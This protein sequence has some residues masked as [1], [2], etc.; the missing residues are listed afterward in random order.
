MDLR[1]LNLMVGNFEDIPEQNSG[2]IRLFLSSTTSGTYLITLDWNLVLINFCFFSDFHDERDEII[3]NSY[4]SLK[5]WC[6]ENYGF[7]IIVCF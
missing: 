3:K 2:L 7:K 1:I 4:R 5:D 6:W